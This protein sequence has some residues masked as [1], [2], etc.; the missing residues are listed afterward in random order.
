MIESDNFKVV[1]LRVHVNTSVHMNTYTVAR[2][3]YNEV[4]AV[5]ECIVLVDRCANM[6]FKGVYMTL[7]IYIYIYTLGIL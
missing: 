4:C 3:Y 7:Y 6:I 1:N 5:G 2:K